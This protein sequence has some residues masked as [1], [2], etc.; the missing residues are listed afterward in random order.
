[1]PQESTTIT[2]SH[3][4]RTT[5]PQIPAPYLFPLINRIFATPNMPIDVSTAQTLHRRFRCQRIPDLVLFSVSL[6]RFKH[7]RYRWYFLSLFVHNH[8]AQRLI[9]E[10]FPAVSAIAV[11][12][13]YKLTTSSG[14]SQGLTTTTSSVPCTLC[15]PSKEPSSLSSSSESPS[16]STSV[17]SHRCFFLSLL[18]SGPST[19]SPTP[20][21]LPSSWSLSSP[22]PPSP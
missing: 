1:M 18:L 16:S 2:F 21:L 12:P 7:C 19:L 9:D 14:S 8:S 20:S 22:P 6:R 5:L 3:S 13:L 10:R 17:Y 4:L 15:D 11:A